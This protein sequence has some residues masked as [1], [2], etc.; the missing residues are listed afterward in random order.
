PSPFRL[1]LSLA[2]SKMS[3][4]EATPEGGAPAAGAPAS[5][6]VA[7]AVVETS[8][9]R[10]AEASMAPP[11]AAS[12]PAAATAAALPQQL[13][14][15]NNSNDVSAANEEAEEKMITEEYKVWKKNTPFLYDIVMTHAL[16]WPSLT[17]QWLPSVKSQES[18]DYAVHK[19]VLGTHTS[20]SE[21]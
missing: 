11:S 7:P 9:G 20:G 10:T 17:V 19:L 3:A 13:A 15:H 5:P 12:P 18:K 8:N 2:Y 1:S 21:Q 4:P 6:E 16:E 14:D